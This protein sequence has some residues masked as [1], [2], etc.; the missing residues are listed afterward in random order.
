MTSVDLTIFN[1]QTIKP[2][3]TK[4]YKN[5]AS[6]KR[7]LSSLQYYHAL[8]IKNNTKNNEVF[9]HFMDNIYKEQMLDDFHHLIKNHQH[10]LEELMKYAINVYKFNECDVTSCDY[11]SRHFRVGTNN[12]DGNKIR[13]KP[14]PN[15]AFYAATM[16]SLHLYVFHLFDL[17]LRTPSDVKKELNHEEKTNKNEDVYFDDNFS[18]LNKRASKAREAT[19]RFNVNSS[20][21]HIKTGAQ[22]DDDFIANQDDIMLERGTTFSDQIWEALMEIDEIGMQKL[23]KYVEKEEY[24]SESMDIDVHLPNK[25]GNIS[26]HV[27]NNALTK[28]VIAEFDQA[29]RTYF[30]LHS[31]CFF[32]VYQ[33]HSF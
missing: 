1:D 14:D 19:N 22:D 12:D 8:D 2:C 7:L 32:F 4:Q 31:I 20:K 24:D 18:R 17:S 27:N 15:C 29:H 33:L 16:D 11:T 25:D 13:N 10:K 23:V 5:C 21:Y 6:I 9:I 30:Y 26:K 28:A 3:S